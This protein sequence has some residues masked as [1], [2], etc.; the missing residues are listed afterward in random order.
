[1][2]VSNVQ[3]VTGGKTGYNWSFIGFYQLLNIYEK[4]ATGNCTDPKCGQLQLEKIIL[5]ISP[6]Q[7][8]T[9]SA[10]TSWWCVCNNIFT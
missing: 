3:H 5:W 6:V 2:C 1:V 10:N 4:T 9:G 8:Y 7:S